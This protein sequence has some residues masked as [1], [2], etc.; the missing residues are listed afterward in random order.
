MQAE[1]AHTP[2]WALSVESRS[3]AFSSRLLPLR[4]TQAK[5]AA[6]K[7]AELMGWEN[8]GVEQSGMEQF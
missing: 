1:A 5:T 2:P 6:Q 4:C 3:R 7:R 8:C